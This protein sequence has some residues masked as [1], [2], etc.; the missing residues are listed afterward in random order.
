M[1]YRLS[2]TRGVYG[3]FYE[4]GGI[5][6]KNFRDTSCTLLAVATAFGMG[7]IST[8]YLETKLFVEAFVAAE[9]RKDRRNDTD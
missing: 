1:N 4:K 9:K 6:L 7:V 3:L 8:I 2:D 5:G